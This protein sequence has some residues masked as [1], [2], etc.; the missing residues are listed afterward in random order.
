MLTVNMVQDDWIKVLEIL[1]DYPYK[2]VAPLIQ[3][4][5]Q[6]LV[7]QMQQQQQ[8]P[9]PNIKANGELHAPGGNN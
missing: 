9:M 3:N 6:Q 5:Q 8:P 4:L 7:P 1:A 2:R